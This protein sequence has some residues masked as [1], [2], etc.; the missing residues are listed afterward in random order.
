[1]ARDTL[2]AMSSLSLP[3]SPR[4]VL[5]TGGTGA[6]G[7]EIVRALC[8]RTKPENA[9]R[10]NASID[11][12]AAKSG[13]IVANYARDVERARRV[14][15]ET[16]CELYQAD[17]SDEAQVEALFQSLGTLAEATSEASTEASTEAASEARLSE[18]E[19]SAV[20]NASV[21]FKGAE[22]DAGAAHEYSC[23]ATKARLF[24]V[25][26]VAGTANDALLVRQTSASWN[27]TMRVN[28]QGSFLIARAALRFLEDGGRLILLAS[29][30]GENGSAGQGAYAAGKAATLSLMRSAAQEGAGRG[31]AVNAIC[32]GFVPSDLT[33]SASEKRLEQARA[34]SVFERFGTAREVASTVQW[35][36][37]PDAAAISSQV[38]H[39]DSR[40]RR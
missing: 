6:I 7:S 22:A 11:R 37:G 21:A 26:H 36:L 13:R 8:A 5:V 28:A 40:S 39:C 2:R 30:V 25:V 12:F 38:I 35:L 34:S 23:A 9:S 29:R 10:E 31:I 1:M 14:Q 17:I 19:R 27:E 4:I 32:P 18:R 3:D 20:L 33:I 24:A 15:A 16:G